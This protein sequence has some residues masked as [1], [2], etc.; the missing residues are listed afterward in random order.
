[1]RS[2]VPSGARRRPLNPREMKLMPLLGTTRQERHD[3][4][5]PILVAGEA[6]FDLVMGADGGLQ[7]HPGGGPFNAARALGRLDVPVAFLGRLS[8][9]R[10]GRA[11]ERMLIDDGVAI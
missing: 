1:M 8:T 4:A 10:F 6:L 2:S 9:D 3:W 7:A 11:L 5:M